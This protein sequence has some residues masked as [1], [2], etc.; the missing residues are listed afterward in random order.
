MSDE[1]INCADCRIDF[2]LTASEADFFTSKGLTKPPILQPQR[3]PPLPFLPSL[4]GAVLS[5][6]VGVSLTHRDEIV[7]ISAS[8]VTADLTTTVSKDRSATGYKIQT[9]TPVWFFLLPSSNEHLSSVRRGFPL[10]EL[11]CYSYAP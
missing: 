3:L 4:H 10:K 8:A 7:R 2:S 6:L 11:T 5:G 9:T 1:V